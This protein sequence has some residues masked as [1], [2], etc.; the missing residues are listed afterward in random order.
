MGKFLIVALSLVGAYL[1][2]GHFVPSAWNTAFTIPVGQNGLPI[3]WAYIALGGVV[4]V[5]ARLKSK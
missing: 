2:I 1:L 3:A 5:G 4:I